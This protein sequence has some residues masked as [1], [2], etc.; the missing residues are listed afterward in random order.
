[1][2]DQA[3]GQ[4]RFAMVNMRDN[5]E[6]ADLALI[7]GFRVG[8]HRGCEVMARGAGRKRFGRWGLNKLAYVDTPRLGQAIMHL[9]IE[10]K[11]AY[12]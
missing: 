1:M 7:G 6:V 5:R 4:R 12:A 8:A 11:Y 9:R 10:P 3:I 2:R